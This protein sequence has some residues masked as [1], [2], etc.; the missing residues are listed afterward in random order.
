MKELEIKIKWENDV[1]FE[2]TT[3]RDA[4][5]TKTVIK[6]E[7]NG[8]INELWPHVEACCKEYFVDELNVIGS[9]M[10]A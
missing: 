1:S 7:E 6:L 10:K 8:F 9:E 2:I 3:K 5:E 4:G